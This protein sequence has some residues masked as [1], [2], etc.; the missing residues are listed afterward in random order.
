MQVS[1]ILKNKPRILSKVIY[2]DVAESL[3]EKAPKKQ[4]IMFKDKHTMQDI[5]TI[6]N[7]IPGSSLIIDGKDNINKQTGQEQV[8]IHNL[9]NVIPPNATIPQTETTIED[10]MDSVSMLS[11][12]TAHNTSLAWGQLNLLM[13]TL[14]KQ[15]AIAMLAKMI[16]RLI[17]EVRNV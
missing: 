2:L 4:W 11:T 15:T 1:G 13:Q 7:A 17:G 10:L 16:S 8:V 12:D 5:N 9:L 14:P 6:T 3:G